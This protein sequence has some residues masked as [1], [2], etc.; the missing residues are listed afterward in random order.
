MIGCDCVVCTSDDARDN[1][2]RPSVL[3]STG[4]GNLLVDT[5]PEMRLQLLR[6]GVGQ[7]TAALITH[8]HADHIFGMDDLRQ[9]NFR[10]AGPIPVYSE[11]ETLERLRSVFDYCFRET[12]TGGG[13]PKLNLLPL[14][15]FVPME[16][17]GIEVL[18]IRLYHGRLPVLGYI[19]DRRFAYCTDV[20]AIPD[21][22]KQFLKGIEHLVLG[23]VRVDYPRHSTHFVLPEAL[24]EIR[25]LS[26]GNA[27]LT[28][29]SH[30]FHHASVDAG[31]PEGVHLAYDGLQVRLA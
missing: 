19:F 16:I 27:W 13:K 5:G 29:L 17:A 8:A 24:D 1:R 22:S 11:P 21:E 20:S 14:E 23:T 7:I 26:P 12:Q 4:S 2:M 30:F 31:L 28:H 9:F 25:E 18:P 10:G 15:P 3:V 6:A